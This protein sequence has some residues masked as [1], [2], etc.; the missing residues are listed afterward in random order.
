MNLVGPVVT[1]KV[2]LEM[3]LCLQTVEEHHGNTN[4]QDGLTLMPIIL[5]PQSVGTVRL[6][7]RDPHHRPVIDPQFLTADDDVKAAVSGN[8][9]SLLSQI[10]ALLCIRCC[11]FHR[12]HVFVVHSFGP[13]VSQ[14]T[15]EFLDEHLP[16]YRKPSNS[17]TD[18]I[19]D[20]DEGS[21]CGAC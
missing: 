3:L 18:L 9:L 7:S 16:W 2:H 21:F 6:Q 8:L 15:V 10:C 17:G 5:H 14:I 13:S 1:W 19:L 4:M 11:Y 12:V 20:L